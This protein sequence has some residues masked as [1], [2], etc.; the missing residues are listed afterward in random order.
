MQVD[1]GK[2]NKLKAVKKAEF[3]MFLDGGDD[4]EILLPRRYVPDDLKVDDE[5]EVFVHFDSEDRLIATT[6]K[7]KAMVGEFAHLMVKSVENVG[8]FLDW[9]LGKDL[10]LPYAEMTRDLRAGQAVVVFVYLD[11]SDRIA[12]SMR[13][14]R[15]ISKEPGDYKEGQQVDLFIGA[16]TD[17]G[18]KAIINGK[19][20]GMIYANEIFDRLVH[21]QKLKGYIKKVREDGKID[22]SLQKMGHQSSEDI[23]PLILQRLREEGGFLP[24]NDKTAAELIYDMFGVSKKKYKMALGDLYK[25]R[26]I[27]V[28]DDG[29]Y[30]NK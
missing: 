24:I 6:E 26:V 7:P 3:G 25:K 8:A 1:I 9:G 10:F 4:G 22:L 2:L 29:I 12:S 17:L 19:H 15:Y 21:G 11:K 18:F 16:E 5:I 30:L 20:W 28:K 14:D 13:L 27:T 23:G